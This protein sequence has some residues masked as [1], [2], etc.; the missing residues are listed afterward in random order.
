MD[1]TLCAVE[2]SLTSE[3]SQPPAGLHDTVVHLLSTLCG[4]GEA[5]G[6]PDAA[7]AWSDPCPAAADLG[8]RLG[9]H[10]CEAD[11]WVNGPDPALA[12]AVESALVDMLAAHCGL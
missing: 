4:V 7:G 2:S 3:S 6:S 5:G 9:E 10:L 11:V 8:E 1:R 12:P